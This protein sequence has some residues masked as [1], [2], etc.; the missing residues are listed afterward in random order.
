MRIQKQQSKPPR[1]Q[2]A[3][4]SKITNNMTFLVKSK[5]MV[6]NRHFSGDRR[7]CGHSER[8]SE[9]PCCFSYT[10]KEEGEDNPPRRFGGGGGGG[11]GG[12][13]CCPDYTLGGKYP[14]G[15]S[16][17]ADIPIMLCTRRGLVFCM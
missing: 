7:L 6:W 4:R 12:Q 1:E 2:R 16:R 15:V 9:Q 17:T 14:L 3:P 10:L 8:E 13:T 11:G 5:V